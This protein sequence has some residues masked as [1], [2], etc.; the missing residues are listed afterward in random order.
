[1]V[2]KVNNFGTMENDLKA[3]DLLTIILKWK[4]HLVLL[5]LIAGIL[6]VIFSSPF[7]IKPKFKSTAVIYPLNM[8]TISD[9]SESEQMLEIIE[10]ND[11]KFRIIETFDLYAHYG[12]NPEKDKEKVSNVLHIY[13][14]NVSFK[15]TPNDAVQIVVLDEDPYIAS[16]MIDSIISFYNDLVLKINSEK[17]LELFHIFEKERKI[18]L[19]AIDTIIDEFSQLRVDHG[20]IN[21]EA[22]VK[23]NTA[24]VNEGRNVNEA[25]VN[26]N[27]WEKYGA[28]Y[29]KMDSLLHY[30][31]NSYNETNK[32][33]E[34]TLRDATKY[35]TYCRVVSKPFP[36]DKKTSPIRWLIVMFSSLGALLLGLVLIAII[37]GN[38]NK[39]D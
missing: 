21:V 35:Q 8:S 1:M 27:N 5:V 24:A 32:L 18:K 4:W 37:E 33:Y 20:L 6:G 38:K 23:K 22:Q 39:Q 17:S 25:R 29:Y 2:K 19:T 12:I 15:K 13:D 11:I 28:E 14:G 10:S 34:V 9:E 7:F 30:A 26:L 31:L 3:K 16:A 36:A